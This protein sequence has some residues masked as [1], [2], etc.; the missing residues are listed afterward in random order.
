MMKAMQR[1]ADMRLDGVVPDLP[2]WFFVGDEYAQ[3]EW[4][5]LSDAGAE[6]VIESSTPIARIDLRPVVGLKVC[7]MAPE[8]SDRLFGFLGRLKQYAS[9]VEVFVTAWIPGV[10]GM[11][12]DRGQAEDWYQIGDPITGGA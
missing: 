2:T 3:P 7:V 11:R 5:R 6:V 10:I 8:W 9:S 12:W 4:W 1:L